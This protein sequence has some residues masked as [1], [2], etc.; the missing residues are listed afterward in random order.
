MLGSETAIRVRKSTTADLANSP[1]SLV[2]ENGCGRS[3][4]TLVTGVEIEICDVEVFLFPVR[5]FQN[6]D[7]KSERR[8]VQLF[9]S[10]SS[11]FV[12]FT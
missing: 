9:R 2:V 10:G 4:C 3:Y 7:V 8:V 1:V 11:Q 6:L 5:H 12:T